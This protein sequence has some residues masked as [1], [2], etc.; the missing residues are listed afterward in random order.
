MVVVIADVV[1]LLIAVVGD[2]TGDVHEEWL[3]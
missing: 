1:I 3:W 2:S